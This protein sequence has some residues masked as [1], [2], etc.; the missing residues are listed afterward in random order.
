MFWWLDSNE[1]KI[2]DDIIKQ[3]FSLLPS[4]DQ[5]D[6]L[7]LWSFSRTLK[8]LLPGEAIYERL[9]GFLFIN[10]RN[11]LQHLINLI[12]HISLN[13]N[14]FHDHKIR[15]TKS[16]HGCLLDK[17]FILRTDILLN[18]FNLNFVTFPCYIFPQFDNLN[19]QTINFTSHL[20]NF[21]LH[22]SHF[23][24]DIGSKLGLLLELWNEMLIEENHQRIIIS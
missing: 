15:R 13:L 9:I 14:K 20:H 7:I 17:Y 8:L 3:R 5:L 10:V 18:F 23:P 6:C 2:R 19:L 16:P 1:F 24:T 4:F 22:I 21:I 12:F 11:L